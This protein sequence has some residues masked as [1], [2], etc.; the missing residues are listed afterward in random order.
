MNCISLQK[1]FICDVKLPKVFDNDFFFYST[2][3]ILHVMTKENL[4]GEKE[5]V[6]QNQMIKTLLVNNL[7]KLRNI[8]LRLKKIFWL[9]MRKSPRKNNSSIHRR[10]S[11]TQNTNCIYLIFEKK[12]KL[13]CRL[14]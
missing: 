13:Q 9:R 14:L 10:N 1:G 4:I 7:S 2:I 6:R 11:F 5:E 3:R 12:C 8:H